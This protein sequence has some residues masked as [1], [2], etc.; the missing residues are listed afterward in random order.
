VVFAPTPGL[1]LVVLLFLFEDDLAGQVE[2]TLR[3]EFHT[4]Q[5]RI[6]GGWRTYTAG[7]QKPEAVRAQREQLRAK[8][9]E[10]FRSHLP[11]AFASDLNRELPAC[12][13]MTTARARPFEQPEERRSP[14]WLDY[15]RVLGL[16]RGHD[17]WHADDLPGFRLELPGGFSLNPPV[18]PVKGPV[19]GR[20]CP[21]KRSRRSQ[22]RM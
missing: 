13:V 2:E 17:A 4:R 22:G 16:N 8:G 1:T 11:G 18:G 10:F 12:E 6:E 14:G 19:K 9:A 21:P 15:L 3:R 20:G 7:L 5:E